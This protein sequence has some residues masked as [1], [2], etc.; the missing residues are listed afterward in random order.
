M[1]ALINMYHKLCLQIP[2]TEDE[3]LQVAEAFERTWQFPHCIGAIDGKH[4]EIKKPIGSGSYYYNYKHTFSIVLMAVVNANY[5]F[6]MVDV[7][8]NGRVSDGGV[9]G[10]TTFGK[11]LKEKSLR[12]PEPNIISGCTEAMPYV[13]VADDAF[14]SLE[15][16]MK[17]FAQK[18]M[19]KSQAIYNYRLSRARRI[20]ENVFGIMSARFRVLLST[21]N[22]CPAKAST[23]VMACCYLHNYLRK[24][25]VQAYIEGGLDMEDED[26]QVIEGNWRSDNQP[27]PLAP[28]VTPNVTSSAKNVRGAFCNYFNNKGSVP[29]QES[30]IDI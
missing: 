7:G 11:K 16:L 21:I 10:N 22:V 20:V 30:R 4:V 1:Y 25:N 12:V 3:W 29:W 14:P 24:R 17:P 5:E 18:N 15:N 26:R 13:F 28:C 6:L 23:I 2:K 19:T 27:L 8:A 9:F